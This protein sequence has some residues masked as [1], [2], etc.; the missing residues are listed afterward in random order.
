M[1]E[2]QDPNAPVPLRAR[3]STTSTFRGNSSSLSKASAVDIPPRH[4]SKAIDTD[5]AVQ[6]DGP[7]VP[8]SAVDGCDRLEILS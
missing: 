8:H 7:L 1:I 4:G 5:Y 6:S 3:M 2:F